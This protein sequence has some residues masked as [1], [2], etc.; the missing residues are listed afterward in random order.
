VEVFEDDLFLVFGDP[1]H[2]A[3]ESRF[4]IIMAKAAAHLVVL[5]HQ[6]IAPHRPA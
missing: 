2:S 5:H 4:I 3:E 6:D 1:D